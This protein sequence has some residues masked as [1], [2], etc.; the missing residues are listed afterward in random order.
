MAKTTKKVA[1]PPQWFCQHCG[2]LLPSDKFYESKNPYNIAPLMHYC[3]E[4]SKEISADIMNKN[5]NFELCVRNLCI[6]FDLPFT[7]EAMEQ[8]DLRINSGT[9]DRD[10]SYIFNYLK[11]LDDVGVPQEYY[12]DLSGA[13]YFGIDL[14]KVAKPTSEGDIETLLQLEKEWGK[15][16]KIEDYLFLE[17]TFNSYADGETLTAAMSNTLHYLCLAIFDVKKL[18][19]QSDVDQ[20]EIT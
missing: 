13:S 17:E 4:C 3:K 12:A 11:A 15:Q 1:L 7:Y 5:A 20:K 10:V 16:D 2:R 18:R 6:F 8:F 9:K 14:L 19:E